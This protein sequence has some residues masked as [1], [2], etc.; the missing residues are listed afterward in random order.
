MS[1]ASIFDADEKVIW[2]RLHDMCSSGE[3]YADKVW[4]AAEK[5]KGISDKHPQW[6]K[7]TNVLKRLALIQKPAAFARVMF[8]MGSVCMASPDTGKEVEDFLKTLRGVQE[9]AVQVR[10]IDAKVAQDAF[11]RPSAE[12]YESAFLNR[13]REHMPALDRACESAMKDACARAGLYFEPSYVPQEDDT[14]DKAAAARIAHHMHQIIY[15]NLLH[16]ANEFNLRA[17]HSPKFKSE[18]LAATGLRDLALDDMFSAEQAWGKQ[19]DVT[20]THA[21]RNYRIFEEAEAIVMESDAFRAMQLEVFKDPDNPFVLLES[22]MNRKTPP[23]MLEPLAARI[24]ALPDDVLLN[25]EKEAFE[26]RLYA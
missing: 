1:E 9:A 8:A 3:E 5:L 19:H 7:A 6:F 13:L 18:V 26:P 17:Q 11:H 20:T 2:K 10:K 4:S 15:A 24:N 12:Q 21:E 23:A 25:L 22:Y 16:P 14:S